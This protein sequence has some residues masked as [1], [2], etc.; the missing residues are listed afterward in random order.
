MRVVLAVIAFSSFATASSQFFN[1][2]TVAHAN[3]TNLIRKLMQITYTHPN[4]TGGASAVYVFPTMASIKQD[5]SHTCDAAGECKRHYQRGN[6]VIQQS[7]VDSELRGGKSCNVV[8]INLKSSSVSVSLL[9]D[10]PDGSAL[11]LA[12]ICDESLKGLA[13]GSPAWIESASSAI[14]QLYETAKKAIPGKRAVTARKA[15][16]TDKL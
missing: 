12:G 8:E 13:P 11:F 3:G 2:T 9:Q 15:M 4:S 5:P 10:L 1:S 7:C 16:S 14:L 6:T